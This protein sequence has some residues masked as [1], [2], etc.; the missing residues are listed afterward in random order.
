MDRPVSVAYDGYDSLVQ[1]NLSA[2]YHVTNYRPSA[3]HPPVPDVDT[4]IIELE[5]KNE[6]CDVGIHQ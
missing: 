6:V 4:W 1:L 2:R 3:R 5:K